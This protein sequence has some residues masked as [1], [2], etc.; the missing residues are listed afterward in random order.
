MRKDT[1]LPAQ[2]ELSSARTLA[3]PQQPASKRYSHSAETPA[4]VSAQ[5]TTTVQHCIR[6]YSQ[7][8]IIQPF[9]VKQIERAFQ[10]RENG[11]MCVPHATD[12]SLSGIN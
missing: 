4:D 12:T 8:R 10:R 5:A 11:K 9:A 6:A 3:H 7:S 1:A 2:G